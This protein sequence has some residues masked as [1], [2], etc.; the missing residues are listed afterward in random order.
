MCFTL[1]LGMVA[2]SV[3]FSSTPVAQVKLKEEPVKEID[4]S[5]VDVER[6]SQSLIQRG[7]IN[8]EATEAEV[9][10]AV[11]NY[12]V[13]NSVASGVDASTEFGKKAKKNLRGLQKKNIKQAEKGSKLH[14]KKAHK[15]MLVLALVEF[16]DYKHNQLKPQEG[17]LY[18]KDFSPEHYAKMLFQQKD[19]VTPEGD[20]LT[21]M[22]HY[23]L[24]QSGGSWT[25]DGVVTPWIM[26]KR[27]AR[28]NDQ[29]PRGLVEETLT[30]VGKVIKGKEA[31]YDQRDPYDLDQDGNVMEPDGMLDNLMLIHA[32]M[33]E[34]AGGGDL[35][36]DAIWSHRWTLQQPTQIPGTS[37]KAYDYMVQPE[38]GTIGVFAHEYAHNLGVPDLYDTTGLGYGSPVGTW[39]LM[40]GGSWNGV[41]AGAEP[42]GFDPWS[43]MYL[44]ATFGGKWIKPKEIDYQSLKK[45]QLHVIDE[46][47]SLK[48]DNKVL[49]VNLP[50]REKLPPT[51]PKSGNFSYFSDLGDNLNTK[52]TSPV[53]DLTNTTK[54]SL[55][56]DS[57]RD[58]EAGYDFLYLYVI[59][60]NTNAKTEIKAYDDV[61]DGWVA[62]ELDLS[63][64]AGKKIKIEFNYV[65]DGGWVQEGFYVD[66]ISVTADGKEIF[67]DDA[68]GAPKFTLDKF[69]HFDGKGKM[70]PTYYLIEYRTHNGMDKGLKNLRRG[71][72]FITSDPGMIVWYYDG[73]YLDN[74]TSKHPGE[75]MIGVVDAHQRVHYWN[76]DKSTPATDRYQLVDAAFGHSKTSEIHIENYA[77]FGSMHYPSLKGIPTFYDRNDYSLKGVETVGKV[78]PKYGLQFHL[79]KVIKKG[80]AVQ[81]ELYKR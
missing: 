43:K 20:R 5:I 25:V 32:G 45:K 63:A 42:S 7:V 57:W 19:Y 55:M 26:S 58:I 76:N 35:G 15:D 27:T 2:I 49:K 53:I 48:P 72:S 69:I 21:T 28:E 47:V 6:L 11:E 34:E 80:R 66:N 68:E 18:T 10:K 1:L 70:H 38:D 39:S 4:W 12:V 59:D 79:K 61:T 41:I 81:I 33:G 73:R 50:D 56:F 54:V 24:Q 74:Q 44:Q 71:S 46:A 22:A 31:L 64:F 23:Y 78:L 60:V 77:T 36:E 62:E 3:P 30:E 75:G 51:Q 67:A 13:K 9:R 40:S 14:P 52:M 16:P 37:L 17:Y 65:T 29:D 8:K